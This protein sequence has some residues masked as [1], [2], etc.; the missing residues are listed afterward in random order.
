VANLG[1]DAAIRSTK[2]YALGLLGFTV[3]ESGMLTIVGNG[4][5][6]DGNNVTFGDGL[7]AAFYVTKSRVVF[8]GIN[9]S[10][11]IQG[12]VKSTNS[13]IEFVNCNFVNNVTA[14]SFE[15][16]SNVEIYK[17]SINLSD[18][19]RGLILADSQCVSSAVGLVSTGNPGPF[20]SVQYGSSLEL[21]NH[22]ISDETDITGTTVVVQAGI[23]SSVV[24]DSDFVSNGQISLVMNSVLSHTVT[25]P[26]VGGIIIDA[27]STSVVN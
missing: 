13:D 18:G 15:Q 26:F 2:Y 8:N 3:Q 25:T 7:T 14:G 1:G 27:S 12:A 23:N 22:K 9:F 19:C 11:F 10:G 16:G 4:V 6:I 20:Y 5:T 21:K 17:G 24:C